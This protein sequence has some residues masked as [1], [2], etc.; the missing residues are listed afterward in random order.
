MAAA[1]VSDGIRVNIQSSHHYKFGLKL[2]QTRSMSRNWPTLRHTWPNV[3]H[4]GF[5]RARLCA[6]FLSPS[7]ALVPSPRSG[8]SKG[9][10]R[11]ADRIKC[12]SPGWNNGCVGVHEPSSSSWVAPQSAGEPSHSRP[13]MPCIQFWWQWREGPIAG[14]RRTL[15]S[16]CHQSVGGRNSWSKSGRSRPNPDLRWRPHVLFDVD[17]IWPNVVRT[18]SNVVG[19]RA[20]FVRF[21]PKLARVRQK[22]GAEFC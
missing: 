13:W 5:V 2:R 20:M 10:H 17:R 22:L 9:V 18:R 19:F 7:Q 11:C 14:K 6:V 21:R 3:R 16:H 12:P 8:L 1:I 4:A 15:L